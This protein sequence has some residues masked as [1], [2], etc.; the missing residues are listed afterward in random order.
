MKLTIGDQTIE[1]LEGLDLGNLTEVQAHTYRLLL[2]LGEGT[3]SER[4]L[5]QQLG[6]KSPLP[7]RSRIRHLAEKGVIRLLEPVAV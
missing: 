3:H 6:L 4:V 1:L 5:V 2:S 7:L